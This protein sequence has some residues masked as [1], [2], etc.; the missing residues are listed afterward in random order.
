MAWEIAFLQWIQENIVCSWLTPIM[1]LVTTLGNVGLIWILITVALL[2]FPKTRKYGLISALAL[3]ISTLICNVCL[4]P[5][6]ARPRPFTVAD[7]Q[8]LIPPPGGY[9]FPSGHTASSFA[10]AVSL[11]FWNKKAGIAGV[12]LASLIA[13]SRMYFFVHY[14]TDVLVGLILG[15]ASAF[16]A[17]AIVN[18]CYKK[19]DGST[20]GRA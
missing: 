6:F 17:L 8:L 9:S 13:F 10:A 20:S 19:R 4:K 5:L 3:L 18:L 7:V 14:P 15:I 11:C 1:E 12:I 16:L 2:I